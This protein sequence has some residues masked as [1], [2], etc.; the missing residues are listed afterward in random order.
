MKK[1]LNINEAAELLSVSSATIRN[2]IKCG[3]LENNSDGI[4]FESVNSLK[5]DIELGKIEK[6][7]NRANKSRIKDI[8]T[9]KEYISDRKNETF[10]SIINYILNNSLD[11]SI[12]VSYLLLNLLKREK[13]ISIKNNEVLT[14]KKYLLEEVVKWN[15]QLSDEKYIPLLNFNIPKH[16]DPIGYIY[17]SLF[18][19]GKKSKMGS[20][21][22]PDKIV[23]K[24]MLDYAND[25]SKFLDP[26]CGTGQF[27][28]IFSEKIKNPTN[29]YGYD[30]DAIA[31][32]IARIN[33]IIKYRNI[34]FKPKIFCLNSLK[35]FK[36]GYSLFDNPELIIEKN[37]D[38]VATNPPWGYHFSN[39]DLSFLKKEYIKIRSGESFSFFLTLG[40]ELLKSGGVCSFILPESILNVKTHKDIREIILKNYKINLIEYYGKVFHKVFSPVIRL[41]IEKSPIVTNQTKVINKNCQYLTYQKNWLENLN[42]IFDINNNEKDKEII[43]K[44][45]TIKHTTLK[46]NADW[47]LGIVTGNNKK[48]L[49]NTPDIEN[50]YE[51]IYTGKEVLNFY[52][53]TPQ[54]FIKFTPEIF[55]QVSPELKFRT[56]EKLVYK[57]ISKRLVFA[58]DNTGA[59]TLN[60]ANILIP[61]IKYSIKTILALFNSSLYQYLYSKKFSSIKVLREHI[62]ELPLPFFS[63]QSIDNIDSMVNQI[64]ETKIINIKKIDDCIF[65]LFDINQKES[66]YILNSLKID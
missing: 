3:Y 24:I 33:L 21:Y 12:S 43:K 58:Y 46:N 62:E 17:Q 65:S 41:D 16:I 18:E 25:D 48:H 19:E 8:F 7:N 5:H 60:S 44:I 32:K 29:L 31:I 34:D 13:I 9:P 52:L 23:K 50:G 4:E 38:I 14:D 54:K 59:L 28:L 30:I 1:K 35:G 56:K 37:F 47:S 27:L 53:N 22:T 26:C 66:D 36:S 45:Y 15:I 6:L 20:Y 11:I 57:F 42:F 55:Q 2:W 64:L 40:L 51:P 39:E 61:K 63:K 49:S 10:S